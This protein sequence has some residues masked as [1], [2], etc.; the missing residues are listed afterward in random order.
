M[1]G[2]RRRDR[3]GPVRAGDYVLIS[4]RA[5][6]CPPAVR[7]HL[8]ANGI[9]EYHSN[10]ELPATGSWRH[11]RYWEMAGEHRADVQQRSSPHIKVSSKWDSQEAM[12]AYFWQGSSSKV[13]VV[14][15]R[16]HGEQPKSTKRNE[17][18]EEALLA[19]DA[20]IRIKGRHRPSIG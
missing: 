19:A 18:V 15:A 9:D 8:K 6:P 16:H 3:V 20:E 11:L 12:E 10:R 14:A 17:G 13:G 2:G 4:V 1:D 5:P 7:V